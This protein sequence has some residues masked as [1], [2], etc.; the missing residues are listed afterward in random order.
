MYDSDAH[1]EL[2]Y[3]TEGVD[4]QH[5]A[6]WEPSADS[7]EPAQLSISLTVSA[8]TSGSVWNDQL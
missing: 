1:L 2:L 6:G 5:T 3:K 7:K 8:L 4:K